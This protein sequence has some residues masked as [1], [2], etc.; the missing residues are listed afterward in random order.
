M[1]KRGQAQVRADPVVMDGVE[2]TTIQWLFS[3]TDGA[4]N[5][6]LR[7]FVIGPGGRIGLHDHTWEHEIYFVSGKG[8][9]FTDKE[10]VRVTTGDALYMPGGEPHGYEN[11]S[12]EELVFLCIIPNSGD[13]RQK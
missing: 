7:R 5:F 6:S 9:A 3:R 13:K 8:V 4:P 2:G 1:I 12:K 11:D 10:R